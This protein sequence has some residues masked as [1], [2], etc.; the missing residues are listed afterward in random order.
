MPHT[1]KFYYS[2]K[3]NYFWLFSNVAMLL[4]LVSC[5][6]NHPACWFWWQMQVLL[7]LF[8]VTL[9]M[10]CYKYL[11]KHKVAEVSEFGIKIDHNHWLKWSDVISAEY[12]E[13]DCCFNKLPVISLRTP[14]HMRYKYNYLQRR[15]EKIGFGAFSIPL[16]DV[17]K[18]DIHKLS[19]II[20]EKVGDI[21]H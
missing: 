7:G 9:L 18:E 3:K 14:K 20:V 21:H 4:L 10:W 1:Q 15:C 13:V 12:R 19:H 8:L 2:F 11:L 6:V 16:Y 5:G 17:E